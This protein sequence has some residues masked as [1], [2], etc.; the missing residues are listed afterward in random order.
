M[1]KFPPKPLSVLLG[2]F[3]I[4]LKILKD[5]R[6]SRCTTCFVDTCGGGVD[7]IGSFVT[8]VVDTNVVDTYG[9]H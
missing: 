2:P 4:F 1:N 8:G 6:S 5:I 9:A 3:Q 7:S